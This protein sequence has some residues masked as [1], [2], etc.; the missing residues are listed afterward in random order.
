MFMNNFLKTRKSV[1]DFKMNEF[2]D[3]TVR[4]IKAF[5]KEIE[6]KDEHNHVNFN[7]FLD[8][9]K[10]YNGLEGKA[11]YSGVMIKSPHYILIN[12]KDNSN[13]SN[14][15]QSYY[16]EELITKLNELDIATCWV[17][18]F[19][20]DKETKLKVFDVYASNIDFVL[21]VGYE[22]PSNPFD[23]PKYS[24]RKALEDIVYINSLDNPAGIEDLE[25]L[26]MDDLFY[27]VRFAP[28]TKNLQPWK[29]LIKD[30]TV[31][32]YLEEIDGEHPLFVDAGIVMYYYKKLSESMANYSEWKIIDR[33][34][35]IE[36]GLRLIA[37]IKM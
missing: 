18:L 10:I 23:L 11:G 28:S 2:N 21:A 4:K 29:F 8:G 37:E 22:K 27:Y 35:N 13:T 12:K 33:A 24:E 1:R 3:D 26:G 7:L 31:Y 14:I 25:N 19:D 17:G 30:Y 34:E 16:T 20:V 5:I 6:D 36:N 32:L 9:K 15:M